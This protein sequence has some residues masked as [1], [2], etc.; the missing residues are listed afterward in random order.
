MNEHLATV[1][2]EYYQNVDTYKKLSHDVNEIIT[3]LLEVNQIKISNMAIRIKSE[4]ALRNKVMYKNKYSHLDEITDILGVRII[5]LFENDVDTILGL[6]EKTFEVCEIVD[7]RK[8][9][10]LKKTDAKNHPSLGN[11]HKKR[12]QEKGYKRNAQKSNDRRRT[13]NHSV[14]QRNNSIIRS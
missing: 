7:K 5:T 1:M 11:G 8:K 13:G 3:T 9:E 12:S 6:L 4:E 14:H 10:R 2:S